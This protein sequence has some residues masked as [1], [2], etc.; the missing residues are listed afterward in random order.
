M[1]NT[2]V[3]WLGIVVLRNTVR[4]DGVPII[5]IIKIF[6]IMIQMKVLAFSRSSYS[7]VMEKAIKK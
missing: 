1:L 3:P 4:K 5:V 7:N 2:L 6:H